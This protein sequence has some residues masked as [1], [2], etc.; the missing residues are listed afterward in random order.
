MIARLRSKSVVQVPTWRSAVG[1][2]CN[3]PRGLREWEVLRAGRRVGGVGG[4]LAG[5]RSLVGAWVR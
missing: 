1:C 2:E 5:P 4:P 3:G